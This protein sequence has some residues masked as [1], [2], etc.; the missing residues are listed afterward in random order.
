R[1]RVV[2]RD[3]GPESYYFF[4]KDEDEEIVRARY[5][6]PL[7]TVT[8]GMEIPE[9]LRQAV[10]RL[11]WHWRVHSFPVHGNECRDGYADSA[12]NV[13]VTF[14]RGLR[15]YLLKYSWS[16]EA[17]KRAVCDKRRNPFMARDTIIL[18]SGGELNVWKEE[19][20]DPRGEFVRHFGGSREDVPDFVGIGLMTDGDQTQSPSEADYG[21]F[22]VM[23]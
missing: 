6:P 22:S 23:R 15:Y 13:F 9:R 18:E 10:K 14:K 11:R 19:E 7:K 17:P 20:L 4:T 12:A 1:F 16:T 3:S 5:R 2:E 8:L 21:G